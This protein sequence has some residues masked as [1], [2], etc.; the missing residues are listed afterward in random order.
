MTKSR[1]L[2]T[3]AVL[4]VFMFGALGSQA[5]AGKIS[6]NFHTVLGEGDPIL[7]EGERWPLKQIEKESGGK[8]E[9]VIYAKSA[10]GFAGPDIWD[11][12]GKGLLPIAEMWAPHVVGK[13][14]WITALELPFVYDVSNLELTDYLREKL[15]DYYA[16]PLEKDNLILLGWTMLSVG[17]GFVVNKDLNP[18]PTAIFKGMKIR[19]SGPTPSWV[20]EILG[21]TPVMMDYAE[22]YE[23]G[24]RG[25]VD[26]MDP[27]VSKSFTAMKF[28][29]VYKK[30]LLTDKE[31]W[32]QF[33][34]GS[35]TWMVVANK[36]KFEGLPKNIQ[37]LMKKYFRE[38]GKRLIR[39][40]LTTNA[41]SVKDAVMNLGMTYEM[42]KPQ[43]VDY[44][45]SKAPSYWADWRKKAGP[46]G[47]ELLDKT[48]EYVKEFEHKK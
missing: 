40:Y 42:V 28:Q 44:L 2:L 3:V 48:L 37:S 18:D 36:Q 47:N 26:G 31:T 32:K 8:F 39:P 29:E 9:G 11:V 46:H 24:Q 34:F 30:A 19:V 7:E 5:L 6:W 21:G 22:V 1:T 10:L 45:R 15:W 17:R 25:I 41:E 33:Q 16:K 20:C 4:A 35:T 12:V 23:A 14:P 43:T 27:L 13:Y 38:G